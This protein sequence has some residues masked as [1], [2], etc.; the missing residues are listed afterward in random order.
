MG[1][2]ASA[3]GRT[4]KNAGQA[5]VDAADEA[6]KARA[7]GYGDLTPTVQTTPAVDPGASPSARASAEM[8][9]ETARLNRPMGLPNVGRQRN[10][11]GKFI[12]DPNRVKSPQFDPRVARRAW[13]KENKRPW[14]TDP[15][16]GEN[17][18]VQHMK[19]RSQG[20]ALYDPKNIF[21]IHKQKHDRY[22]AKHGPDP[23]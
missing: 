18:D 11:A 17:F 23:N 6:L 16:T 10:G 5:V 13:V 14:P 9:A 22:H 2:E 20:G 1:K 21:P 7:E 19:K 8:E 3:L 12:P 4:L 15:Q